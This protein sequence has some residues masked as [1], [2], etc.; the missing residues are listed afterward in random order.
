MTPRDLATESELRR[1]MDVGFRK[2]SERAQNSPEG[3]RQTARQLRQNAAQMRD[4]CDRDA[5]FRLAAEY[6]RRATDRE[7]H[8]GSRGTGAPLT[9]P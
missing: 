1:A 8:A 9:H 5:M 6:E 7:R 4:S 2:A 3:M